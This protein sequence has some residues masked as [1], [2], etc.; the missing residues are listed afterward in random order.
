MFGKYHP[1]SVPL[2]LAT[3]CS[4]HE[5]K[6]YVPFALYLKLRFSAV[7]SAANSSFMSCFSDEVGGNK[8]PG[9]I[10]SS[11]IIGRG[12]GHWPWELF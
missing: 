5:K 2:I 6:T 7:R 12:T 4:I 10:S 1:A 11:I 3:W 9:G 8:L